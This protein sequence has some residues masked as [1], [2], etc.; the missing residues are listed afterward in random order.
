LR[1]K[2]TLLVLY[3]RYSYGLDIV[4]LCSERQLY[5]YF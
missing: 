1:P 2:E 5:L 4:F 3:L